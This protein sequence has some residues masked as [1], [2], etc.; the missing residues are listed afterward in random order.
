MWASNHGG[1]SELE[2]KVGKGVLKK[3]LWR[4]SVELCKAWT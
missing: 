3:Q 2:I 1:S 4:E